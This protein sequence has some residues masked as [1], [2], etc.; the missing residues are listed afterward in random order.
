[1]ANLRKGRINFDLR[2]QIGYENVLLNVYTSRNVLGIKYEGKS[3]TIYD[4]CAWFAARCQTVARRGCRLGIAQVCQKEIYSS[5]GSIS[6]SCSKPIW[7]D[8]R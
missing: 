2:K 8:I 1:M 3:F 7:K 6:R 5:L 4:Q